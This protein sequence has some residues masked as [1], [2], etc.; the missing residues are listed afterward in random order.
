MVWKT[1]GTELIWQ[2]NSFAFENLLTE[3]RVSAERPTGEGERKNRTGKG[4]GRWQVRGQCKTVLKLSAKHTH[5]HTVSRSRQLC[6]RKYVNV[7]IN[8]DVSVCGDILKC[9]VARTFYVKSFALLWEIRLKS[10]S[11]YGEIIIP[12]FWMLRLR[13]VY[14]LLRHII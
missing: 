6:F 11:R 4:L 14:L 3:S 9:P 5:T 8:V 2:A 12:T 13:R 1:G 7:H 10:W